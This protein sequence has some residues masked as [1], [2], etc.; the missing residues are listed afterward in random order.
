MNLDLNEHTDFS[1]IAPC[2]M[3]CGICL[4]HLREKNM[5]MGCRNLD[6]HKSKSRVKCIIKN[7]ARLH[8][9]GSGFCFE[10]SNFPC[11]R[12]KQLDKRYRFKYKMSMIENLE[13][14]RKSG[15][16]AFISAELKR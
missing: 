15:L 8:E 14:I 4:A 7:C 3:N 16:E 10:C 1:L 5:C 13:N 11:T 6:P 9:T 12:L 2:G